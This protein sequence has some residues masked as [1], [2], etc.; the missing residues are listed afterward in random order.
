MSRIFLSWILC[1]VVLAGVFPVAADAVFAEEGIREMKGIWVTTVLNLDYPK[2]AT[3]D[4]EKLKSEALQIIENCA[5]MGYNSIF[6]QVRPSGDAIYKSKFV[7]WSRYLTGERGTAPD[8][9]FDPLAFWVEE[10]HKRG[11]ELHAWL[12]PYRLSMGEDVK[13]E[14]P[15]EWILKNSD[16]RYYLNPGV[17]AVR[18]HI[19]AV[20]RELIENYAIDGI[21]FDDYFY[22]SK[23]VD[24][25]KAYDKYN[26]EKLD[27]RSWRIENVNALIR[28]VSAAADARSGVS[29]GVSPFGIWANSSSH[30]LGSATRGFESLV[31][32]YADTRRWVKEGWLD[33]ICPQIYWNIGYPAA[34]FEVLARWWADVVRGTGVKLY[35]GLASYK[36]GDPDENSVWHGTSEL[37]RQLNLADYLPEVSGVL[38]FRYSFF[39]E[40]GAL[41]E[42]IK[43]YNNSSAANYMD[44]NLVVGRPYEDV[45]VSDASIFIGGVSNP[46]YPL[47]LNGSEV[48]DRTKSGFFGLYVDLAFGKNIF[49]FE[50]NGKTY[51]RTI[52]RQPQGVYTPTKI[53]SIIRALPETG[54][55]YYPGEKFEIG[56]VAPAGCSV[57]AT[58]GGTRYAL[59][60]EENVEVGYPVWYSKEIS[61]VPSGA[62][63]VEWLGEVV[64]ECYKNGTLLSKINSAAPTEIIM[65]G[66][67]LYAKVVTE[68]ADTFEDNSRNI[69]SYHLIPR[70]SKEYVTGEDGDL[71]R[72]SSGIWV[73]TSE[74]ELVWDSLPYNRVKTAYLQKNSG[75]EVITIN[76]AYTPVAYINMDGDKLVVSLNNLDIRGSDIANMRSDMA[77]S[78]NA[79]IGR[80][81]LQLRDGAALGGYYIDSSADGE[82]K[83]V[84]RNKKVSRDIVKPLAGITIMLDPGHG[85]SD[86]GGISLFGSKYSE[87]SIVLRLSFRLKNKLEALGA[88]VLMTRADDSFISLYDRL[89]YSR[90]YLPDL[91]ISMHTDSI[92]DASD[93]TKIKGASVFYRHGIA[94]QLSDEMAQTIY[95]NSELNSR[96]SHQYNFYVCRGTWAPSL[97]VE[98]GFAPSAFDLEFIMDDSRSEVLLDDYVR[99]IVTYFKR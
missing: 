82:I 37:L 49:K 29:F 97:L 41:G 87:K 45:V 75:G 38:H 91:F 52:T 77:E 5:A 69:G 84:L 26:P 12:N 10:C 18:E 13:L 86:S 2:Q 15:A 22:P 33:Y 17:P 21:H 85:G 60:Q 1:L 7:P 83:I 80:L 95:D 51:I 31:S 39:E 3:K 55:A 79:S 27:R 92:G 46:M 72:L 48:T 78:I 11:I 73:R 70:G 99:N 76:C 53:N 58:L 88:E 64:Y 35:I 89:R 50:N 8:G 81:E 9:G 62:P 47:Y 19:V 96:G 98:N 30:Y 68:Y 74:V 61:V 54:K 90:K 56:C 36:A 43:N 4:S 20:V 24:D 59:A 32:Q 93:L 66:A 42:F 65:N 94:K 28:A 34:D 44:R 14:H 71:Y 16:G 67:A 6:L 25:Q 40:N 23:D 63:R 57:Y